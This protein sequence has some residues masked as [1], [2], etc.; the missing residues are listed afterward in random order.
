VEASSEKVKEALARVRFPNV[1]QIEH[2]A[3]LSM[4][5]SLQWMM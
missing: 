3:Q 2:Y 5:K 4:N 1:E